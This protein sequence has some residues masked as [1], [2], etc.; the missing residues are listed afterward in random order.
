V[1][2]KL[3]EHTTAHLIATTWSEV[4]DMAYM[5]A[6]SAVVRSCVDAV[7]VLI[8]HTQETWAALPLEWV[9]NNGVAFDHGK[10]ETALFHKVRTAPVAAVKV[11]GR[12]SPFNKEA[13]RW[14]GVWLDS[15]LTLK[16]HNAWH[17]IGLKKGRNAMNRPNR[18]TRQMGLSPVNCRKVMT[19]CAQSVA[20]S[21]SGLW[22]KRSDPGHHQPGQ[23]TT[24]AS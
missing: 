3:A 11:G 10:T 4:R 2:S 16:E 5:T 7:A 21:G 22:W 12:N 18:L 24:A 1:I 23:R 8:N 13:T 20:M 9:A 14:L 15:Q 17:A 19:S 6:S